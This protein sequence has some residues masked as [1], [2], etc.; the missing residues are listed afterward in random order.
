MAQVTVPH[1]FFI[2]AKAD[3]RDW[4][5]AVIRELIQNSYDAH[6]DNIY[7]GLA[8]ANGKLVLTCQDDGR[9][10]T[11]DTL[12]NVLLAMG[13]SKKDAGGIGGFG[14]AKSIL[15]FA[16][17]CY[18]IQTGDLDVHGVGGEYELDTKAPSY[19][20][21]TKVTIMLDEL[22]EAALILW[23]A[24]IENY[25]GHSY[26]DFKGRPVQIFLDNRPLSQ[27]TIYY[28]FE[29]SNDFATAYYNP[30]EKSSESVFTVTSR[31]LPMFI[32]RV[33]NP[34]NKNVAGTIDLHA[35]GVDI[36]T[37]NRDGFVLSAL[38]Q[39]RV[40]VNTMLNTYQSGNWGHTVGFSI[41]DV[42]PYGKGQQR[43]RGQV[44]VKAHLD[45]EAHRGLTT[46][47]NAIPAHCYPDNMQFKVEGV[48][49][50]RNAKTKEAAFSVAEL[51]S[52]L[53]KSRTQA[54]AWYWKAAVS[55]VLSCP[56]AKQ[57]GLTFY[58]G[59]DAIIT[60]WDTSPKY[61]YEAQAYLGDV[62]I[63]TGFCFIPGVEGLQSSS[64]E[65]RQVFINPLLLAKD[66]GVGD[67]I[68]L[69]LHE[70]T[71][72]WVSGH[73]PDFCNV[74]ME[75]RRSLRRDGWKDKLMNDYVLGATK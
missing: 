69:A 15:Y 10:M 7:L 14:V 20:H 66:W 30:L 21:G 51:K 62:I 3:Y 34:N 68:D 70:C 22:T 48:T 56:Y 57:N 40:F 60:D 72:L 54:L 4:R 24:K 17:L 43:Q 11:Q 1:S 28:D 71:H 64:A 59:K 37:A 45:D 6:A 67:L 41:N 39:F 46:L 75:L 2:K 35:A 9:G 61:A 53:T 31:G 47:F 50:R 32:E 16:H 25:V 52:C 18:R 38:E 5:W 19:V 73:G 13:G 58:H 12:V 63:N 42:A 27:D 55:L 33:Y 36:F 23:R 26:I 65:Q 44:D 29:Y 8:N 49:A 74:E